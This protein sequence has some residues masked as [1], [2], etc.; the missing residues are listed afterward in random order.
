MVD[1]KDLWAALINDLGLSYEQQ[2]SL[3]SLYASSQS[4]DTRMERIKI[5]LAM[6]G[7]C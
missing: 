4:E 6:V 1:H 3:T 7:D 2:E 5:A